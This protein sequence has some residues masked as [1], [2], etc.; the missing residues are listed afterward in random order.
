MT[1]RRLTTN[2]LTTNRP[3]SQ[4]GQP[5]V[6]EAGQGFRPVTGRAIGP[7]QQWIVDAHQPQSEV[8][9]GHG[10]VFFARQPADA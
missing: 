2:R 3:V 6:G 5:P 4:A 8:V 10:Q 9:G 1:N 7:V